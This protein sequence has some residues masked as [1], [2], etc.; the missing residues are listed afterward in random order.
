MKTV[1]PPIVTNVYHLFYLT[2][3]LWEFLH[4]NNFII[5]YTFSPDSKKKWQ[6]KSIRRRPPQQVA[7]MLGLSSLGY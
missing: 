1:M 4:F 6:N 2:S 3:D 7:Q 5:S